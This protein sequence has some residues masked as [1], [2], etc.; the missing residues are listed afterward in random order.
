MD[1]ILNSEPMQAGGW[2]TV[3][4]SISTVLIEWIS[5]ITIND[6]LQGILAI[7]GGLFLLYRLLTQR[8]ILR[9][10]LLDEKLKKKALEEED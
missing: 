5:S 8:V 10:E 9:N 2:T 1:N 4:L 3:S 6:A 7:L